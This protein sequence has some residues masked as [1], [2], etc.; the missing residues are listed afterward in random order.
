M[1]PVS[2]IG[3][4]ASAVQFAD[5]GV[6]M[7]LESLQ[8][9]K[10]LKNAPQRIEELLNDLD[11]SIQRIDTFQ[12]AMRQ[13]SSSMFSSLNAPQ[14]HRIEQKLGA[15][16]E[17]MAELQASLTSLAMR[18]KGSRSK[19]AWGSVVSV[20]MEKAIVNRMRRIERLDKE[21]MAELELAGL[22]MNNML[23]YG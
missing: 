23:Q 13:T 16:Y 7:L 14:I 10:A 12:A 15:A 21:V 19:R 2:A 18:H 1:D 20:A 17:A 22:E 5:F 3:V 9:L 8:L 11:G 4:A 6:R